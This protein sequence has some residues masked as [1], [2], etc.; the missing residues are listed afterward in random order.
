MVDA[1]HRNPDWEWDETV[2][3]CDLVFQNGWQPLPADDERIVELSCI[4]RRMSLH[5]VEKRLSSFRNED[6]VSRKTHNLASSAPDWGRWRSNG[7]ERD[8]EVMDQFRAAPDVMHGIA[9]DLLRDAQC[10]TPENASKLQ[11]DD[12]SVLEGRYLWRFHVERERNPVL[13]RKKIR[14]VLQ[15]G[16]PLACEACDFDFGKVYGDRGQGF[17]ECHHV[18]PLHEIGE[19]RT[20]ITDL[21]LLC[22][23]CHRMIHR[24]PPWPTPAQLRDIIVAQLA[25]GEDRV[26]SVIPPEPGLE[27]LEAEYRSGAYALDTDFF[28]P[29]LA[30]C[31]S[32]DR[33]V[34]YFTSHALAAWAA[35]VPRLLA[36]PEASV[37]LVVGPVLLQEDKDALLY[38]ADEEAR[39][40]YRQRMADT[41]LED[42]VTELESG[43]DKARLQLFCMFLATGRLQICFAFP[44]HVPDADIYHEKFGIFYFPSGSCVAFSGSA[45]ETAGGHRRNFEYVDVFR[46][47][48]AHDAS[49]VESKISKFEATWDGAAPGLVIRK[50]SATV[51]E[52]IEVIS[53]RTPHR[54][55][56]RPHK[57]EH[58]D[59]AR[60]IFL[61]RKRG[62]LEMATGTGKTRTALRIASELLSSGKISGLI[63]ST[64]GNDLLD[65]WGKEIRGIAELSRLVLYR[66]YGGYHDIGRY[67]LSLRGSVLLCSRQAL[68]DLRR[69]LP[70]SEIDL[71]IVQD[72]V[73]GLGS[74]VMR[75]E[76]TGFHARFPYVLGLS[77]TP[78]RDYDEE[79]NSFI[80]DEIGPV[81]FSFGLDE[82]IRNGILCPFRYSAVEYDLT[83]GD[84]R[85]L[86]QVFARKE[87]AAHAGQPWPEE[88]LYLE[89]SRVYKTAEEKPSRF[90][91]LTR[92]EP[93]VLGSSIVF[94]ETKELGESLL[95]AIGFATSAYSTYFDDDP[96][97]RLEELSSGD[98]DCL[99]CC[100]RLSEGID[101]RHLRNVILVSSDKGRLQTIQRIGR[102]LRIDPESPQ[103]IARVTDFTWRDAPIDHADTQRREWLEW[104]STVRPGKETEI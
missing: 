100:K 47:W 28:R 59:R 13:R 19:C 57:W 20:R 75:R 72:E 80:S 95:D 26:S 12:G 55:I 5:P 71:L 45:N 63:V 62:I 18:R 14:N 98:L 81:I 17:I 31:S 56:D 27:L 91:E 49:R 16:D 66:H 86:Q 58:Q 53:A 97:E 79:G 3:A 15:L 11:E 69:S 85:R 36:G 73:H 42:T 21:A 104:L 70:G 2:L 44:V 29:C 35:A 32:Y 51:L 61:E 8:Q 50:P 38:M 40:S 25:K 30:R 24:K 6:G 89:L 48:S 94:V 76:L 33:A 64:A 52:R 78:E 60:A 34:G 102:T 65:Q 9:Q 74:P 101:I 39:M 22:S 54:P 4:L 96:K 46:S 92:G 7:S 10:D 99:V 84:R 88:K 90:R 93:G 77:A 67:T 68:P 87:A 82:A 1:A 41:L 23:N 103:K 43:S 83:D 37:R